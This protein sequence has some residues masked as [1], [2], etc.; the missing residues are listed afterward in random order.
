MKTLVFALGNPILSDDAIGWIMADRLAATLPADDYDFIKESGATV[1]ILPRLAGYDRVVI[2]D[3]IQL[4]T[5]PAGSLHRFTLTDLQSTVRHSSPHDLNFA[6]AFALGRE[7]GY[8]I[9]ADIRIYAIEVN[10]LS[11]FSERLSPEV[12]AAVPSLCTEIFK[13]LQQKGS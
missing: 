3:A 4:G 13:D 7:L 12:E 8:T 5:R 10:D 1:D 9:P 6:T 2:I 11:H